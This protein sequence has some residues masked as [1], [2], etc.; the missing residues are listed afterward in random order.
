M[1]K[2]LI[3]LQD[4]NIPA[5][6]KQWSRKTQGFHDIVGLGEGPDARLYAATVD[7]WPDSPACIIEIDPENITTT[8]P[9]MVEELD[10]DVVDLATDG[11]RLYAS[12]GEDEFIYSLTPWDDDINY[13]SSGYHSWSGIAVFEGTLYACKS[14]SYGNIVRCG[15]E[16]NESLD[17]VVEVIRPGYTA[18]W[19][20]IAVCDGKLYALSS[21]LNLYVFNKETNRFDLFCCLLPVTEF[22]NS[23]QRMK[24]IGRYLYLID[25]GWRL[26]RYDPTN[27]Q[28]LIEI[29]EGLNNISSICE[30]NGKMYVSQI[31]GSIYEYIPHDLTD[32]Y[33]LEPEF[34]IPSDKLFDMCEE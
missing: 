9:E 13:I 22:G 6:I 10:T 34:R 24:G 15:D 5:A 4:S 2:D 16:K 14:D 20:D 3:S 19:V 8:M 29:T 7:D 32:P 12:E 11:K 28:S 27:H 31:Q 33:T 1:Y 26:W 17:S 30:L 25:K 21:L 23:Y 18:D